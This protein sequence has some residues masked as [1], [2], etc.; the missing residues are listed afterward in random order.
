M[1]IR[2]RSKPLRILDLDIENRPLSYLAEDFTTGEITAIA[3]SFAEPGRHPPIHAELLEADGSHDLT[4]F[5]AAYAEADMVTGH[6][7]RR[8]DLPAISGLL[9]ERGDAPLSPKLACDTKL[10]L[11]PSKLQSLSQ[12]NLCAMLGCPY[13]KVHMTQADWRM[14]NR[15]TPDGLARTEL[16]VTTDVRQHMWLRTKLLDMEWLRAPKM[17][18]R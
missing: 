8:H 7:I 12:E 10:D 18:Q 4:D 14:A 16:R 1:A 15:L 9:L 17:W 11:K 3:W 6:F 2:I 5:L 13:P